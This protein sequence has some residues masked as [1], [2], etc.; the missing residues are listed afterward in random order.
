MVCAQERVNVLAV[1]LELLAMDGAWSREASDREEFRL[2]APVCGFLSR[3]IAYRLIYNQ[4]SFNFRLQRLSG[5]HQ[6]LGG[7]LCVLQGAN[8]GRNGSNTV[9]HRITFS[10]TY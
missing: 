9:L 3:T 1:D 8:F 4:Y 5:A 6:M 2:V 7:A 10:W